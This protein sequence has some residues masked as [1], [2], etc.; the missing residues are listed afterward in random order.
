MTHHHVHRHHAHKHHHHT[1]HKSRPHHHVHHAHHAHHARHHHHHGKS[2]IHKAFDYTS[3]K[4][5][6]PLYNDL[7]RE[8]LHTVE[9]IPDRTFDSY[10]KTVGVFSNPTFLIV[11]GVVVLALLF[12]K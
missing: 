7:V 9:Q 11:G 10:D 4:I 12:K 1:H 6:K 3:E 2:G 5:V 8:P